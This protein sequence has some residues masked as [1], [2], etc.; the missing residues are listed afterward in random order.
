MAE[1]DKALE[2]FGLDRKMFSQMKKQDLKVF[3]RSSL[4]ANYSANNLSELKLFYSKVLIK[5]KCKVKTVRIQDYK[6][7]KNE[8]SSFNYSI[9]IDASIDILFN[10]LVTN[11]SI[12]IFI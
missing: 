3:I 11:N 9:P 12:N 5:E 1:L 6:K 8:S 7:T 10:S 4:K 2:V